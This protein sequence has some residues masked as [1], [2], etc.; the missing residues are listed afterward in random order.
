[1][2]NQDSGTGRV[3]GISMEGFTEVGPYFRRWLSV[4]PGTFSSEIRLADPG[5][6]SIANTDDASFVCAGCL[7]S[8]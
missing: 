2:L 4:V 3:E 6:P 8:T 1:M 5:L 7:P